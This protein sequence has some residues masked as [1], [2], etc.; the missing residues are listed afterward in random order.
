MEAAAE[1][2]DEVLLRSHGPG[3]AGGGAADLGD[4]VGVAATD[5]GQAAPRGEGGGGAVLERPLAPVRP[6]IR[7]ADV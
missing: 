5:A 4:G 2:G 3:E 7:E 6:S 1:L